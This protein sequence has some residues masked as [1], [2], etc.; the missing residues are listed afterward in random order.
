MINRYELS[1]QKL[2]QPVMLGAPKTIEQEIED[3][4]NKLKESGQSP[5]IPIDREWFEVAF[6]HIVGLLLM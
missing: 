5:L 1:I 6:T 4:R 2:S 3:A